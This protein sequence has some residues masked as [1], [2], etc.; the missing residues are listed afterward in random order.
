MGHAG[1]PFDV[2]LLFQTQVAN[3][4]VS[5]TC[6]YYHLINTYCWFSLSNTSQSLSDPFQYVP[7]PSPT[8]SNMSQVPLWHFPI[9]PRS[10]P[11]SFQYVLSPSLSVFNMSRY[12]P[13]RLAQYA[14]FSNLHFKKKNWK[15]IK[16]KKLRTCRKFSKLTELIDHAKREY[17]FNQ[18]S[19]KYWIHERF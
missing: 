15:Q 8:L 16:W 1:H 6:G 2:N 14:Q 7:G 13:S 9:C 10:L 12:N 19:W 4:D 18:H 17:N 3:G 5:S 11:D